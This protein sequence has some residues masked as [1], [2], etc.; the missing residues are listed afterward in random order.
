MLQL[1]QLLGAFARVGLFT[2]GSGY[3]MLALLQREV[4]DG[5]AWLT[6]EEFA[7]VVAIAELTPGPIMVN[8]A[9]FVGYRLAGVAGSIAATVGL[10]LPP[11]LIVLVIARFYTLLR[12]HPQVEAVFR[13]LRPV[14][15]GL[16]TVAVIRLGRTA[17]PDL[18][19]AVLYV[20]VVVLVHFL[21]L[22]P[23]LAALGGVAV[24]IALFR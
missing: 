18:R 15:V 17:L 19:S 4:I 11:V 10:I 5:Y 24:G 7:D 3:A 2:F 22:N 1:L 16:I 14:V 23:I 6:P 12:G 21:G 20:G 8:L 13:G 9:T